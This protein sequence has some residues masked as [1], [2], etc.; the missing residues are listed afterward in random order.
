[1]TEQVEAA[2]LGQLLLRL[3]ALAR[4]PSVHSF[5]ADAVEC[6][7][8]ALA[9]DSLLWGIGTRFE[10][11]S[12][13]HGAYA[14]NMPADAVALLNLTEGQ[15]IVAQR[16]AAHPGVAH[17]FDA[18]AM[19]AS[20]ETAQL[21]QYQGVRQV[22]IIAT[23]E[24]ATGLVGFV[25]LG[26]GHDTPAFGTLERQWLELLMPH[27]NTM[28]NLSRVAQIA[29]IRGARA[30]RDS[31]MAVTDVKGILH[32]MEPGF[33]ALLQEEWPAW[34]GPLLP[35][36]L[37]DGAAASGHRYSGKR[38]TAETDGVADQLLVTLT[39]KGPADRLTPQERAVALAY[40]EGLSHKE[41]AQ[42][43]GM[44][45]ATVRHH[46]REVYAKLGVGDKAALARLLTQR[47]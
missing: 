17:V 28:L 44:A 40:A 47:T 14:W 2:A 15:N 24:A 45:P 1:M 20:P 42:R 41:V 21:A 36:A 34:R 19:Q 16:C 23:I 38:L 29:Q 26:R 33:D 25:A 8:G 12:H 46:L 37:I 7:A 31:R 32:V 3:Y 11:H 18:Q 13:F 9:F 6:L 43:L 39:R 4:Q 27:L 35:A 22:C 5:Q 30:T 10:G